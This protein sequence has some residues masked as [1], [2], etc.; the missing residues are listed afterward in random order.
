MN[1]VEIEQAISELAEQPFD[2]AEFAFQF[3]IAFG[4]PE[5]T[6][7]RLR[8]GNNNKSDILNGVLQRTNI[9]IATCGAGEVNSTLAALKASPET[10]KAK[11]KFIL[12]TDG[13]EFQAEDLNSGETIACDYAKF[14]NHFGFFLP[15]A[16]IST[17]K[18]IRD[19]PI[20][21]Q[22]TSRLNRLYVELLRT[23]ED[24]ATAERRHDMN[25]FMGRLIFCYFA[26]DTNIFNGDDLFTKTVEQM[27]DSKSDN[28]D[29]VLKELFR[30][31]DTPFNDRSSSDI[32][33]WADAM[34][35]VNGGL[36]AGT[37]DVPKFCHFL[38]H[39]LL[40]TAENDKVYRY[41]IRKS[42]SS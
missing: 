21:I 26:E 25:Q 3:L 14:A 20:D 34:P 15:L 4:N 37:R 18:Q 27:S 17:V 5:T 2:T 22:A 13:D 16:G 42:S 40:S 39:E 19:N 36:F 38:G 29:H 41:S 10:A 1:A 12:A 11:A 31:M 32:P 30:A 23:N 8:A 24:W 9:H 28:T 35:Y 6:I 33:R 7:R